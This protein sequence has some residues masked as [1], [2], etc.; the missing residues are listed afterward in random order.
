MHNGIVSW[1]PHM[2]TATAT[3][4]SLD[5]LQ[6][7]VCAEMCPMGVWGLHLEGVFPTTRGPSL[8]ICVSPVLAWCGRQ[9]CGTNYLDTPC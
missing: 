1:S 6:Q 7:C 5:I 2:P 4:R 8:C 9:S 3:L